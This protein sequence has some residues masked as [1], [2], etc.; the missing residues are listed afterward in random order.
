VLETNK[1]TLIP[2]VT[3]DLIRSWAIS[4]EHLFAIQNVAPK[5]AIIVPILLHGKQLGALSLMSSDSSRQYGPADLRMAEAIALRSAFFLQNT[6]LYREAI[7]ATKARDDVFRVVAHDL[8]NPLQIIQALAN[9]LKRTGNEPKLANEF[10]N[11]VNRMNQLIQDL[12]DV[13]RLRSG[14]LQL[15]PE[16]LDVSQIAS[17]SLDAQTPLVSSALLEI[18]FEKDPNLPPI[19]ADRRRIRQV[20]E[21]LIGN[22]IKF[23][24][25]GGRID[26]KASTRPG[27]ILFSV[28]DT[29]CGI[30]HDQL[31]HL[32]DIFWQG[33]GHDV[34][35]GAGLGLSIVK[36]IV[37]AHGGQVWVE[38][39]PGEGTTFF[40][41]L[42]AALEQGST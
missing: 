12:L 19:L 29:G 41:T 23:T 18:G 3:P 21:N 1:P 32:F 4:E 5:S 7:Q 24:K 36:G 40:F 9:L 37:D 34:Y 22:A 8:R 16:K 33:P 28:A 6:H 17:E 42:P 25:P 13:S 10:T 26:L 38:S 20:F 14:S 11:A 2:E 31:P 35:R 27:E 39:S 15:N 30:P